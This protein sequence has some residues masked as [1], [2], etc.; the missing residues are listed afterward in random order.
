ME[1]YVCTF[2]IEGQQT[3]RSIYHAPG[4]G[5]A[6]AMHN[7][8]MPEFKSKVL[9]WMSMDSGITFHMHDSRLTSEGV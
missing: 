9:K 6:M 7:D 4:L 5:E 2:F 1:E 8:A 3:A